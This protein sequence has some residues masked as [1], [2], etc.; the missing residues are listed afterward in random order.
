MCSVYIVVSQS[1]EHHVTIPL[2]CGKLSEAKVLH[3]PG[4][5]Q[6]L[7]WIVKDVGKGVHTDVEIGNVDPHGLFAHGRLVCVSRGL[8]V[9][10]E[11]NDGGTHA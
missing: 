1:C 3:R 10:R 8:V 11:G 2:T 7:L 6:R 4:S 9:V 5:D